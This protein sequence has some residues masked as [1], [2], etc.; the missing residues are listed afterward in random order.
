MSQALDGFFGPA[1][2]G[3][4]GEGRK[5]EE[6]AEFTAETG[7]PQQERGSCKQKP[8]SSWPRDI[9][10]ACLSLSLSLSL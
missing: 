9:T 5:E 1:G 8:D 6:I 2:Q 10:R 4:A 7:A 3:R